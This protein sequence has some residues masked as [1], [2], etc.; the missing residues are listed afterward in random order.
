MTEKKK[1]DPRPKWS[2]KKY[3]NYGEYNKAVLNWRE[4]NNKGYKWQKKDVVWEVRNGKRVPVDR[5]TNK[6]LLPRERGIPGFVQDH[7]NPLVI[8]FSNKPFGF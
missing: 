7:I 2:S 3:K 5:N 6:V 1:D 4:R 8:K